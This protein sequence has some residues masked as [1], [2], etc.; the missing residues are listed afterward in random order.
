MT[1]TSSSSMCNISTSPD[2]TIFNRIDLESSLGSMS[3]S[4]REIGRKETDQHPSQTSDQSPSSSSFPSSTLRPPPLRRR[5]TR[6]S[7][8]TPFVAALKEARAEL[9]ADGKD[10]DDQDSV[11]QEVDVSMEDDDCSILS[12]DEASTFNEVDAKTIQNDPIG[13][14]VAPAMSTATAEASSSPSPPPP[15]QQQLQLPLN[16]ALIGKHAAAATVSLSG[17]DLFSVGSFVEEE[18]STEDVNSLV[19]SID[20]EW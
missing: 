6:T 18:E 7:S 15:E 1:S 19:Q 8:R 5:V 11:M 14:W 20:M 12:A 13:F 9:A 17:D 3:N 10:D 4:K 16:L 2:A